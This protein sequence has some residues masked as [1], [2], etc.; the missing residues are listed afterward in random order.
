LVRIVVIGYN[1]D[2]YN[3]IKI[4]CLYLKQ[5]VCGETLT[6]SNMHLV[7]SDYPFGIFKLFLTG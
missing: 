6:F 3:Q 1:V 7:S 4:R 5:I 2:H